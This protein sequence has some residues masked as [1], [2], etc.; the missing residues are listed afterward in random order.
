MVDFNPVVLWLL[1][2]G[3]HVQCK[4]NIMSFRIGKDHYFGKRTYKSKA[5]KKNMNIINNHNN[6]LH[7]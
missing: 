6:L 2:T 1:T 3:L 5:G 7:K 4:N